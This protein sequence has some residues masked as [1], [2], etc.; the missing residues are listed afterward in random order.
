MKWP[1]VSLLGK[2]G[3]SAEV[4][5]GQTVVHQS[6]EHQ[7][8]LEISIEQAQEDL[9][10]IREEHQNDPNL[11]EETVEVLQKAAKT[12][13]VEEVWETEKRFV[14]DS[15]YESVRAAVR[16]EDGEEIANTL[17]AWILGF[18]FVTAAAGVNMFLSMRNPAIAISTVVILLL[19][20]PIGMFWARV[21][22]ARKFKTFGVVWS[23]NPG[24]WNI[25]EHTVRNAVVRF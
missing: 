12:G 1:A 9:R 10:K 2:D 8:T 4:I 20:H 25:K 6:T 7:S 5:H 21:V 13:S 19:V 22:P 15:P 11:P 23:F 18:I 16:R 17:R 24:P 3:K 14:E